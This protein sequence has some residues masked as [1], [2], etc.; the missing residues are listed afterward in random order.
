MILDYVS[1]P[2]FLISLTVGLF[3]IY[4]LGP[5]Q[6][7]VYI[8]PTPKNVHKMLFKDKSDECFQYTAEE[9]ECP[10]DESLIQTAR[11]QV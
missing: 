10:T 9:V 8:F 7:I 6:T 11:V 5:E 2:I 3:V 1:L 4:I